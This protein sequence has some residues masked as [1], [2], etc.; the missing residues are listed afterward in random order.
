MPLPS[1]ELSQFP[2]FNS[3]SSLVG[4]EQNIYSL[5]RQLKAIGNLSPE[6]QKLFTELYIAKIATITAIKESIQ[7]EQDAE[8]SARDREETSDALISDFLDIDHDSKKKKSL[9]SIIDEATDWALAGFVATKNYLAEKASQLWNWTV[10]SWNAT[11][12]ALRNIWQKTQSLFHHHM[13]QVKIFFEDSLHSALHFTATLVSKISQQADHTYD[14]ISL[15]TQNFLNNEL[16][17]GHCP[18]PVNFDIRQMFKVASELFSPNHASI[19]TNPEQLR[20]VSTQVL[21]S[22]TDNAG[23]SILQ[24]AFL[25]IGKTILQHVGTSDEAPER[26]DDNIIP[27]FSLNFAPA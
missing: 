23:S 12:N 25:S 7:R 27:Q 17:F 14:A 19:D 15:G 24:S 11:T 1:I 26:Q 8:Q 5:L 21:F 4:T 3:T 20:F 10:Y 6:L 2:T 22:S 16:H 18:S 9:K 13:D